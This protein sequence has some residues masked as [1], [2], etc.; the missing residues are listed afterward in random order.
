MHYNQQRRRATKSKDAVRA[1]VPRWHSASAVS[2]N[3]LLRTNEVA[4]RPRSVVVAVDLVVSGAPAARG[5]RPPPAACPRRFRPR[6]D[7]VGRSGDEGKVIATRGD[8]L[9]CCE[10]GAGSAP[11][12]SS[13]KPCAARPPTGVPLSLE[14]VERTSH[15]LQGGLRYVGVD[16]R[17]P[18]TL[19]AE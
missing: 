17:A 4:C 3:W 6:A 15:G 14:V 13:G 1:S 16:M 5:L 9:A 2:D 18:G 10:R 19:V 7:N 11:A 8:G 12:R